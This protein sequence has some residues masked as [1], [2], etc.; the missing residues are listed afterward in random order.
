MKYEKH[1][2]V[3][4]HNFHLCLFLCYFQDSISVLAHNNGSNFK[5]KG[6]GKS[7]AFAKQLWREMSSCHFYMT[8]IIENQINCLLI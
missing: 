8:L 5:E 2:E 6:G 7:H 3:H 1:I 4:L